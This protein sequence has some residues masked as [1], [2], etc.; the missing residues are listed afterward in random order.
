ME[1]AGLP[2]EKETAMT[3]LLAVETCDA[4][5]NQAFAIVGSHGSYRNQPFERF[6]RDAKIG[7][8]TGG[9]AEVMKNN[10]ARA[11]L[12]EFGYRPPR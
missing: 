2:H 12:R 11:V 1:D 4:A 5:T 10:I 9:S 6:L 3:K 7:H 8:V